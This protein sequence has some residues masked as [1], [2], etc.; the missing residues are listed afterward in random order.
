[1]FVEMVGSRA[2]RCLLLLAWL[3]TNLFGLRDGIVPPAVAADCNYALL[4]NTTDCATS[5]SQPCPGGCVTCGT[6]NFGRTYTGNSHE[7]LAT[8]GSAQ[9][10]LTTFVACFNSYSCLTSLYLGYGCYQP[11]S[12]YGYCQNGNPQSKCTQC[13][14]GTP[15][16]TYIANDSVLDCTEE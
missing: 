16:T 5:N 13:E 12:V 2:L 4:P 11:P 8:P 7:V 1:M 3:L 10:G 6:T 9:Q 14:P 15:S